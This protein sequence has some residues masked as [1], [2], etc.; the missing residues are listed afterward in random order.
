[1][2]HA[3]KRALL[4][5][6]AAS[7]SLAFV[8]GALAATEEK[9]SKP[10][11]LKLNEC[12]AMTKEVLA[13]DSQCGVVMKKASVTASDIEKMRRCEGKMTG[14]VTKDPDCAAM[15]KKHPDLVRGHG[16]LEPEKNTGAPAPA[17]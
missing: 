2:F 15:I 10:E 17:K 4:I 13:Q 6:A 8:H 5:A 7:A 12:M 3:A 11:V 9:L 14:D 16:E 1:M